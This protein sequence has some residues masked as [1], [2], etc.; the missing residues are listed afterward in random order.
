[1]LDA[2]KRLFEARP[3][4]DTP[5]DEHALRLATA[6]LLF[7]VVQADGEI[8]DDERRLMRTA[9]QSTF[10]L[11]P[12]ELEALLREAEESSARSVSLYDFTHVVDAAYPPEQKKRIVEL[13]WLVAF[14]DAR[15]D[16]LE[17]HMVRKIA[18][19][20]HVPHPDFIEAKQR[21]RGARPE[22]G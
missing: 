17:E 13:L 5:P 10:E 7:E 21:A 11:P 20:L 22:A 3:A 16:A 8:H 6:A 9:I 12:D 14:A 19:L 15:K 1:M 2:L 4:A 18:G